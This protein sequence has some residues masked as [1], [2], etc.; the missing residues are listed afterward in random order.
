MRRG[1]QRGPGVRLL[2]LD[3]GTDVLDVTAHDIHVLHQLRLLAH[4][5]VRQRRQV[6]RQVAAT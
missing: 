3:D 5:R 2:N 6:V 1:Q 4:Q